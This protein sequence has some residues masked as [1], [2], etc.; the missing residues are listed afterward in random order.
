MKTGY[1]LRQ[2]GYDLTEMARQVSL[3]PAAEKGCEVDQVVEILAR[4]RKSPLLV[5]AP[6]VDKLYVV[7]ALAHRIV[8]GNIPSFLLGSR[9]VALDSGRLLAGTKFRGDLEER[10]LAVLDDIKESEQATIPYF[11][12]IQLGATEGGFCIGSML[13]L[14]LTAGE[15]KCIASTGPEYLDYFLKGGLLSRLFCVVCT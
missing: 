12:D 15:L 13:K 7:Q 1:S 10:I 8:S 2:Y 11:D 9:I 14:A 4:R 6:S 5:G 3:E